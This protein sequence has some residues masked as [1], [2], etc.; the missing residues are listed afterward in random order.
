VRTLD[1]YLTYYRKWAD[2]WEVQALLRAKPVAGDLELGE[3]FRRAV[4]P[5]RYAE[6]G[7]DDAKVREIRRIKARVDSERLPRGADPA[8]HTKLG[9]GGLADVEWT[10][11]LLQLRYAHEFPDLRTTS[12]V[13]GLRACVD[14]GLLAADD[15]EELINA[16]TLAMRAR[17]AVMLVRGKPGD[18]LPKSPREVAAVASALGYP[19]NGASGQFVDDYLRTTRR[20]H[21][22]VERVF[23]DQ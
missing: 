15:A 1:S 8:T 20:A 9:R 11:Q 22:V 21:A 18:Q 5:I 14:A 2:V 16:W 19:P 13:D 17:N 6:G 12:T 4:D 10:L 3:R 7:V 23:Y